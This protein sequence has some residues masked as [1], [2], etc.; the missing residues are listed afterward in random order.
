MSLALDA[1]LN[2]SQL[3]WWDRLMEAVWQHIGAESPDDVM[4]GGALPALTKQAGRQR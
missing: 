4:S 2:L 3:R 1:E